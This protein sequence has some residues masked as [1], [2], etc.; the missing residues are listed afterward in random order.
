MKC[1]NCGYEIPEGA[2]LC[3]NCGGE[4]KMVPEFEPEIEDTYR[5][6]I[7]NITDEITDNDFSS[8]EADA[9]SPE[10]VRPKKDY[11]RFIIAGGIF[12][13]ILIPIITLLYRRNF[14]A[15]YQISRGMEYEEEGDYN[16]AIGWYNKALILEPENADVMARLAQ[17]Y[18]EENNKTE[19]EYLLREII[20]CPSATDEQ[21]ES[22][23][24]KLIAVYRAR[25]DY[26]G[27][28]ELLLSSGSQSIIAQYQGYIATEP[29]F[30]VNEGYYTS[31]QPLKIS[32]YG[33]GDIYYTMDGT[34]PNTDSTKYTSPIL[35][36]NGDYVIK[37]YFVNVNGITSNIVTKEYHISIDELEPPKVDPLS[38]AFTSPTKIS[39]IDTLEEAGEGESNI[40]YTTDGSIPT[41]SSMR[42]TA[43]INMP[44][45]ESE[46]K[47][48]VIEYGLKSPVETREYSLKLDAKVS[49]SEAENNVITYMLALGKIRD[50]SGAADDNGNFLNY[51]FQFVTTIGDEGSYYVVAELLRDSEGKS[52][53][54]GSMY[55]VNTETGEMWKYI[56]AEDDEILSEM[57]AIPAPTPEPPVENDDD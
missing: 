35:L 18:F 6:T 50:M 51:A 54:T 42:Y 13:I 20:D 21:V 56:L 55:A 39:V 4:I 2:L 5:E 34:D 25:D 57:D 30:S 16:K 7:K 44:L 3:E 24:G 41:E 15:E 38:G 53:R 52:T 37:A 23:Y 10:A 1:P 22:A 29:E 33:D 9:K 32:A 40:Y 11:F 47:F 36:E 19:Y 48:I 31:I 14:S 26:K 43:P 12:L 8:T 28:N 45:G 46:F 17:V 27:I 49:V